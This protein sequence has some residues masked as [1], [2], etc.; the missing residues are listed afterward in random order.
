MGCIGLAVSQAQAG[1]LVRTLP[2]VEPVAGGSPEW[3]STAV[4]F[5]TAACLRC[6]LGSLVVAGSARPHDL[7][8]KSGGK[9]P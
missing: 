2:V 1:V 5:M 7:F 8:A 3:R 9:Q 6:E 4:T